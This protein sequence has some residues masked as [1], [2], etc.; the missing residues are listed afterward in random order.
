MSERGEIS[1]GKIIVGELKRV[2]AWD[3]KIDCKGW[4][5]GVKT[6]E[7]KNRDH[8]KRISSALNH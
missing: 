2:K 4:N 3:W 6:K 1:G 7:L 8:I 5:K